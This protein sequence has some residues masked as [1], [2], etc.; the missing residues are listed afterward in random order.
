MRET[1][2]GAEVMFLKVIS[3]ILK[4]I[5]HPKGLAKILLK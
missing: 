3:I 2:N 5:Y 1:N 4:Q